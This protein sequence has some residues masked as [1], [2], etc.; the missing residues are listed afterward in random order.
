MAPPFRHCQVDL[1]GPFLAVDFVKRRTE[2]KLWV[3]VILCQATR[4][5][6]LEPLPDY[7]TDSVAKAILRLEAAFGRVRTVHSDRGTQLVAAGQLNLRDDDDQPP[8]GGPI[9]AHLPDVEWTHGAPKA[10]WEQGGAERFVGLAKTELRFQLRQQHQRRLTYEEY[11][12]LLYRVAATLN[13]RPLIL[14][15]EIGE[16]ITPNHLLHFFAEGGRESDGLHSSALTPSKRR[17]DEHLRSWWERFSLALSKTQ[18][19]EA[20]W[21]TASDNLQAGDVVL[22]LDK[23]TPFG[24]FKLARVSAVF[25][26]AHNLVRK[27]QVTYVSNATS[28][29]KRDVMRHV[30]TLAFIERPKY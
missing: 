20:K 9:A 24:S 30:H 13:D 4:A 5:V 15:P 28:G 2:R 16:A 27:V 8:T 3:L 22:M 1:M 23:P 26:D 11:H 14:S 6:W 17:L 21:K 12:T 25:P 19:R 7:S 18:H 10:S 29:A